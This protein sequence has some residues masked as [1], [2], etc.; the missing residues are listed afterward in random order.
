MVKNLDKTP[1]RNPD[2][3][4]GESGAHPVG[5]AGGGAGGAAAGAAIGGAVGGPV[6]ALVGGAIGAVA[7]GAA[8]KG[9]AESVNPTVE[10][11]YWRENYA[12]RPYVTKE[13]TYDYYEP[14]YRHGWESATKP[15]Y[16]GRRFEDVEPDLQRDWQTTRGDRTDAWS[17]VR[18]A[19]RD[20]YTRIHSR[21]T[22][23]MTT[24]SEVPPDSNRR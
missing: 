6:G 16:M 14:A 21:S 24:A 23:G 7:G 5:V 19:T 1:D 3:I 11:Q 8:G 10:D 13:R 12:S 17:D 4:T 20:A 15:Q 18:E 22:P 2:P 9:V